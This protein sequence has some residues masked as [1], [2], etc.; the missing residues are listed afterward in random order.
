MMAMGNAA[1][2]KVKIHAVVLTPAPNSPS[3]Q[4]HL[5]GERVQ[6]EQYAENEASNETVRGRDRNT[7]AWA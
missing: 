5:E 4:K 2:R 3:G 1:R 7:T 6:D